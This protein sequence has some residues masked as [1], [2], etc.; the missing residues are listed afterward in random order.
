MTM[1]KR[2]SIC[3]VGSGFHTKSTNDHFKREVT[4][5]LRVGL[6]DIFAFLA[7]VVCSCVSESDHVQGGFC[8]RFEFAFT[9][10]TI[11]KLQQLLH[12]S[13]SEIRLAKLAILSDYWNKEERKDKGWLSNLMQLRNKW[14]HPMGETEEQ[15]LTFA[16]NTWAKPPDIFCQP[17]IEVGP[18]GSISFITDSGGLVLEPF[19]YFTGGV[20]EVPQEFLGRYNFSFRGD[21]HIHATALSLRWRELRILDPLLEDPDGYEFEYKANRLNIK[22]KTNV[23]WWFEAMCKPGPVGMLVEPGFTR[24]AIYHVK[25]RWSGV[26]AVIFF[27]AAEPLKILAVTLGFRYPPSIKAFVD[28]SSPERPIVIG[29]EENKL[30]SREFMNLLYWL[31]ELVENNDAKYIRILVERKADSLKLDQEKLWDRLP[32]NLEFFLRKPPGASSTQLADF[33]WPSIK[34]KRFYGLF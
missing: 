7:G 32:S 8:A 27:S 33:L 26:A 5:I 18:D 17:F 30:D 1:S 24:T 16:A 25:K 31:I 13:F 3:Q 9:Q 22:E 28:F 10:P 4:Q 12:W 34:P 15:I 20:I 29:M 14:V 23:P 21:S 6:Q 2:Y 19:I 11:G